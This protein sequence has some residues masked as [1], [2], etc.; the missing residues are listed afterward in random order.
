[1]TEADASTRTPR[2][3]S[4]HGFTS[5]LNHKLA[6]RAAD[7]PF[8]IE[9]AGT[10]RAGKTTAMRELG[11]RLGASG[12][13]VELI[14][15]SA[16]CCP[17]PDKHHPHFNIWTFCN[18]LTRILAAQYTG[19]DVVVVDRGIVDAACWMDWYRETGSLPVE[20]HGDI[21][22]FVLH[23]LWA[24]QIDLVVMMKAGPAV[25]IERDAVGKATRTPGLIVNA[26]TL[27]QFNAAIDRMHARLARNYPLVAVETTYMKP[28]EVLH[29]ILREALSHC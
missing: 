15:E 23:S 9:L 12:L 5:E 13:H 22:R 28:D 19:A 1:M 18:T 21:D 16:R 8:L 24:G 2:S 6:M 11:R 27:G 17:I 4:W 26:D 14:E 29:D 10:P 7:R 20:A 25:A 3:A